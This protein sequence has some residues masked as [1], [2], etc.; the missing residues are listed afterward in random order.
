MGVNM[1][2][3]TY[4]GLEW[5][6][7]DDELIMPI[8]EALEKKGIVRRFEIPEEVYEKMIEKRWKGEEAV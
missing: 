1:T 4:V 6:A 8:I 5:D 7:E 2:T 3:Y